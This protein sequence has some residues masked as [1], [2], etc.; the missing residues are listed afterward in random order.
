MAVNA[1]M[2]LEVLRRDQFR[3]QYCGVRAPWVVLQVD[4][5][6]P[7]SADGPDHPSNL[8]AACQPCNI[9]KHAQQL[10]APTIAG[11]T[12]QSQAVL[13]L[14]RAQLEARRHGPAPAGLID[15]RPLHLAEP[16][17]VMRR[18]TPDGSAIRL[19]HRRAL[20]A[21][22]DRA[23]EYWV[24]AP[25]GDLHRPGSPCIPA[26]VLS[27]EGYRAGLTPQPTTGAAELEATDGWP[28]MFCSY[29]CEDE[30][31]AHWP[32]F[33]GEQYDPAAVFA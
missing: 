8:V 3:C 29:C 18:M 10:D 24:E 17:A 22:F 26:S 21:L 16:L 11:L 31:R 4:H 7:S 1:R 12:P 27:I 13:E 23:T 20:A 33:F 6:I 28:E 2:R 14:Q 25:S 30:R 32:A 15:G 9:G 5:V 19:Q